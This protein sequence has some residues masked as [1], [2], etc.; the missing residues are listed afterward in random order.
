MEDRK[1][2]EYINNLVEEDINKN[3]ERMKK[4]IG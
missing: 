1:G 2:W 3:K 4:Y